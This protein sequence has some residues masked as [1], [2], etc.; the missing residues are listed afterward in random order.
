MKINLDPGWTRYSEQPL[1]PELSTKLHTDNVIIT[2]L[3]KL[4]SKL[5]GGGGS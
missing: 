5:G 2:E 3:E 4:K 1:Q